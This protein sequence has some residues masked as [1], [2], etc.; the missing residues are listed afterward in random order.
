MGTKHCFVF[1]TKDVVEFAVSHKITISI[2]KKTEED[3]DD[4]HQ[5]EQHCELSNLQ[6]QP[7]K[8]IET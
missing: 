1:L 4:E 5:E 8:S 3:E 2:L 7:P 6:K